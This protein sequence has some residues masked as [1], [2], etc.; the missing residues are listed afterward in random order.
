MIGKKPSKSQE[1]NKESVRERIKE[2]ERRRKL[3]KKKNSTE[4]IF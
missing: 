3:V 2:F 4:E 1:P